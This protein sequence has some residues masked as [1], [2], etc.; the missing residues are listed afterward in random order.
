MLRLGSFIISVDLIQA[1]NFI[2]DQRV[3]HFTRLSEMCG[4]Q[5]L[6][7]TQNPSIWSL[8]EWIRSCGCAW[9]TNPKSDVPNRLAAE[10]L[11]QFSQNFG[12]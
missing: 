6:E 9:L 5:V 12:L 2:G 1:L 3:V 7:Q 11:L 8:T 10:A 4:G